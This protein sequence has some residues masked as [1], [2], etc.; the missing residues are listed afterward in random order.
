MRI[1]N[2]EDSPIKHREIRKVLEECRI[3]DIDC[4]RNLEDGI[5]MYKDAISGGNP[6]DLIITDMWYPPANGKNEDRSGDALIRLAT[7][8]KW[9][10]PIIVCSNQNYN[11]PEIYGSLYFS[12]NADWETKL[13]DYIAKLSQHQ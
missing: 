1:I 10:T 7:E 3:T 5:R 8:E 2:F 9:E 4:V 6:Y 11:Y 12:E 13:R